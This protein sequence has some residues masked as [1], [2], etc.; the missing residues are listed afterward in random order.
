MGCVNLAIAEISVDYSVTV[1]TVS[2]VLIQ[3][4]T[5]HR[6]Q[7]ICLVLEDAKAII[8]RILST[9]PPKITRYKITRGKF[10]VLA[11]GKK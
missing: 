7:A 5:S 8:Y 3:L 11:D 9:T 2:S 6:Q 4:L 10:W 1:V